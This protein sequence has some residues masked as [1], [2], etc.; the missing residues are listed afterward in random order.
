MM[1]KTMLAS[2]GPVIDITAEARC[3]VQID[4][5]TTLKSATHGQR[6]VVQYLKHLHESLIRHSGV[7]SP[8]KQYPGG[9]LLW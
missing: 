4:T 6:G 5:V 9:L 2:S 7:E 3:T 1:A 8:H